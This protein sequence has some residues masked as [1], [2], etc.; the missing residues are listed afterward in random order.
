MRR[1]AP[2]TGEKM[3]LHR[4]RWHGPHLDHQQNPAQN[5]PRWQCSG[6]RSP[7][8]LC[9]SHDILLR[10]SVDET[11]GSAA[12]PWRCPAHSSKGPGGG[13]AILVPVPS[14]WWL[15]RPR[16]PEVL[17]R[18]SPLGKMDPWT[19]GSRTPIQ[20]GHFT[21]SQKR[22]PL[23]LILSRYKTKARCETPSKHDNN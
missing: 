10:T 13:G 23:S 9:P 1:V 8:L 2:S 18:S 16:Q 3:K 22:L 7:C 15:R 20:I 14:T 21:L 4:R 12:A 5:Y 17:G 19:Q 11:G 6:D